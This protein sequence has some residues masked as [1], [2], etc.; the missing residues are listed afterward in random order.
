MLVFELAYTYIFYLNCTHKQASPLP[1]VIAAQ[2]SHPSGND[3]TSVSRL[4]IL[5]VK[6]VNKVWAIIIIMYAAH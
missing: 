2:C 3:K 6:G 4:E 1:R 5:V